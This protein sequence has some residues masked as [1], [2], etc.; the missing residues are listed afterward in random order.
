MI[1]KYLIG[2]ITY[3]VKN[4]GSKTTDEYLNDVLNDIDVQPRTVIFP[5]ISRIGMYRPYAESAMRGEPAQT[6]VIVRYGTQSSSATP[7]SKK[8]ARKERRDE[9]R[10]KKKEDKKETFTPTVYRLKEDVPAQINIPPIAL[11][12]PIG[13]IVYRTPEVIVPIS[14][15]DV[16]PI[17]EGG[18]TPIPKSKSIPV[19][20]PEEGVIPNDGYTYMDF[21]GGNGVPIL[22]RRVSSSISPILALSPWYQPA[23]TPQSNTE[24]QVNHVDGIN[25]AD[26]INWESFYPRWL[27]PDYAYTEVPYERQL[28]PDYGHI[29]IPYTSNSEY[30][31]YEPLVFGESL[32]FP[33]YG[34]VKPPFVL[35][36]NPPQDSPQD[37]ESESSSEFVISDDLV[38]EF[39]KGRDVFTNIMYQAYRT[40]LLE[41]GLNP[42]FAKY[43][44]AQDANES[45]WGTKMAGDFNFGGITVSDKLAAQGVPYVELDSHE[46]IDGV[47]T[48]KKVKF[49]KFKSLRDYL[50]YKINLVKGDL[51]H[52]VFDESPENYL[53]EVA[54]YGYASSPIYEQSIAQ[55]F[56]PEVNEYLQNSVNA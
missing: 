22:T 10:S 4:A 9:R 11:P 19:P 46:Y 27:L 32:L 54:K 35:E 29:E 39:K 16:V 56:L 45:R 49:R 47:R 48:P 20:I 42:E 34:N 31:A 41:K 55:N 1:R 14:E 7:E 3:A 6:P 18:T 28:L 24:I 40:L 26:G 30:R 8:R 21:Y 44:V 17:P 5:A 37:S 51:Y 33:Q 36:E 25:Y 12:T 13:E 2:G 50:N 43:L 38:N 52:N 53:S 15:E 23:T